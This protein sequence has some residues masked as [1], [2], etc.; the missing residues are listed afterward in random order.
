MPSVDVWRHG[1][2]RGAPARLLLTAGPLSMVF[3]PQE[4]FLRYVRLGEHE[5]LRGVYAAVRDHNWDTIAPRVS[6]VDLREN[7]GGFALNFAVECRAEGIDFIWQGR[8]EGHATGRV[9]FALEGTARCD[10]LRNRIGFCVLHAAE[11]AGSA[12]RVEKVGG[13]IEEGVLPVLIAPHQPFVDMAAIAHEVEEGVWANVRFAGD[14]FEMEDQ[15]NWTDAS[16]KTYCTPLGL[17]FPV[18]VKEGERIEQSITIEVEGATKH[19]VRAAKDPVLLRVGDQGDKLMRLGLAL[20][21]DG[22]ESNDDEIGRL[23]ALNVTHLRADLHLADG[24]WRAEWQRAC[25]EAL[26]LDA[27]L[28]LAVFLSDDGEQELAELASALGAEHPSLQAVW[29]FHENEKSTRAHWLVLAQR[30]LGDCGAIIGAGSNAYFTELNRERP[31]LDQMQG[32]CYSLNPQV[33]AFDDASLVETLAAQA[34]TVASARAFCADLPLS[35]HSV[36]LQPRFNPNAT[37]PEPKPLPGQLPPQVDARQMSLFGAAWTA[38]SIKYL[39]LSG[40]FSATYYE[41]CG[42]RGVLERAAG[43]PQ[44]ELF[45][46]QPGGVF[47]LYHVLA[48][49]GE[50]AGGNA[51]SVETSDALRADALAIEKNGRCRLLVANL[52]AEWQTVQ[53]AWDKLGNAP[54]LMRLDEH[55]VERAVVDPE[56]YRSEEGEI[57]AGGKLCLELP[58]FAVWRLDGER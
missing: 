19:S 41:T 7:E 2:E 47:P 20:A 30:T 32:V 23:R 1:V 27:A 56:G 51:C 17:P 37:G 13:A 18:E 10:F 9:V 14:V 43:A 57:L 53:V 16:Y 49:I 22:Q 5:I 45:Q 6:N 25:R 42:W 44:P 31:G 46:S 54:R 38:I 21:S 11:S 55:S 33:H 52:T 35:V 12:C 29:I 15:R 28:E 26:A 50:F 34:L 4:A 8:I 39:A 40:L 3:E 24:N 48:D 58:P 36:T